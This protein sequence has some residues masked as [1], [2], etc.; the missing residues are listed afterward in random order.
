MKDGIYRTPVVNLEDL[1]NRIE[2]RIR[3]I[4]PEMLKRVV[5][6]FEQRLRNVIVS[7]GSHFENLLY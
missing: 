2:A 6:N 1:K 3:E 7:E 5:N 4:T